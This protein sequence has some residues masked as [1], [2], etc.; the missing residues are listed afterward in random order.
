VSDTRA[1]DHRQSRA[2]SVLLPPVISGLFLLGAWQ[3]MVTIAQIPAVILP[4]PSAILR[5][6]LVLFPEL[7]D[8][9]GY[10][11]LEA[12]EA[13]A[14]GALLG[15]AI[16]AGVTL[17]AVA[18]EAVFPNLILLQLIP[19]IALAPLFVIWFG[20]G[21]PAHVAFGVFVSF[22]P[23]A[24][25]TAT[26]LRDTDVRAIDLCRSL[27]ASQWQIFMHVRVPFALSHLFTGLK[28]AATLV[29]MGVVIGEFISSDA[30]LGYFI[31]NAG[32]RSETDKIFAGL[33]A[34][35]LLG[36]AFYELIVLAERVAQRWWR[37]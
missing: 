3:L 14:L 36:L 11:G 34:L 6:F 30:G 25:V 35:S 21:A 19:K 20:F 28:I 4:P 2:A 26:G 27:S 1:P 18:R 31:L 23:I 33:F 15:I 29:F 13:F 32:A 5:Q 12:F 9:A 10:T 24:L 17:S 16:A 37:G 8:Q 7:V 22:F